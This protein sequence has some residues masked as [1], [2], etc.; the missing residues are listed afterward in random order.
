MK[1]LRIRNETKWNKEIKLEKCKNKFTTLDSLSF[2]AGNGR[3]SLKMW[4]RNLE[5]ADSEKYKKTKS[6]FNS[7][8]SLNVLI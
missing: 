1:L 3:K 8:L 7:T 5:K 2:D 6:Q 4:N